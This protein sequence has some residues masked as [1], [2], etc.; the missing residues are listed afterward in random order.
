[1]MIILIIIQHL[2]ILLPTKFYPNSQN[3]KYSSSGEKEKKIHIISECSQLPEMYHSSRY[4][5]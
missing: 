2:F 1:M 5:R 4:D 3:N